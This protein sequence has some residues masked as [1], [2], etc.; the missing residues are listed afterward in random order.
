MSGMAPQINW[1][2]SALDQ[3]DA[4]K[5]RIAELERRIAALEQTLAIEPRKTTD[6]RVKDAAG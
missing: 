5:V 2:W 6:Q 3:V 4:L 1:G